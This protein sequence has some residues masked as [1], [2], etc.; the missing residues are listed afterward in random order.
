MIKQ[1][2]V[3]VAAVAMAFTASAES[4]VLWQADNENGYLDA[5]WEGGSILSLTAD[6]AQEINAGD[7]IKVT[8]A[9][10]AENSQWTSVQLNANN[11]VLVSA[12]TDQE[13]P[14]TAVLGVTDRIANIIK[15]YGVNV[16]GGN[17]VYVSKIELEPS[18][19]EI[20]A[21]TIW[22][23]PKQ[24]NWGNSVEVVKEVF[25]NVQVGD[26]LEIYVD[27][28]AE[29]ILQVLFG[30]WTGA[31][32]ATYERWDLSNIIEYDEAAGI[33]T[34]NLNE[35]LEAIAR[36]EGADQKV[37]NCFEQLKT[38]GL[39]MQGPCLVYQIRLVPA[40]GGEAVNYYAVGGFQGW[41][42]EQP[43]E[44]TFADGVYTLVAEKASTMKISTLAG[45][46]DD[47]NSATIAP[48]GDAAEDGSIPF[49]VKENYEFVL[50]YEAN[51]TV[52]IDPSKQTIKF[53][54]NDAR[55]EADIYVRGGMNGW[56]TEDAWKFTT[57]DGNKY[58][59][60]NVSIDAAT[61][62]KIADASWGTINYGASD[63][64]AL[65][66]PVVL[67]YNGGNIKLAE[68]VENGTLVFNLSDK[69]L[70]VYTPDAVGIISSDNQPAVYYNLQ[71]VKVANP[72]EGNIYIV[73]KGTKV[74]KIAF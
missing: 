4:K 20:N 27:S 10:R 18:S 25:A 61:E 57:T 12:G 64:V 14:Y 49:E 8:I 68:S 15:E 63:P 3:S 71:G 17:N 43:A 52:T 32:I 35:D 39:V 65:N 6:E 21:N 60:A 62:F 73:K 37:F 9:G 7:V 5:T 16:A 28:S 22:L 23:G 19:I 45:N 69:T 36:G 66:T 67:E 74:S 58:T 59:L 11:E 72:V 51:W 29:A 44:F 70:T 1:L 56:G 34:Y 47:F 24:C 42:V 2:L 31:N 54:T 50:D 30:G 55:P 40:Q 38:N 48:S 13:Y 33:Y 46:W 53:V 41:N 26:K